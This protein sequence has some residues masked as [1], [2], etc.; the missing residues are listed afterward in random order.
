[1]LVGGTIEGGKHCCYLRLAISRRRGSNQ[2]GRVQMQS[3]KGLLNR[4][5]VYVHWKGFLT[6]QKVSDCIERWFY[7]AI[8]AFMHWKG[9][10]CIGRW[11]KKQK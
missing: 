8:R 1:M 7:E 6:H 3:D 10:K 2:I 11:L 5:M 9:S 4:G